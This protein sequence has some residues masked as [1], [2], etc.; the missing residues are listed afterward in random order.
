MRLNDIL[1]AMR[2]VAE[3]RDLNHLFRLQIQ[4][5][6]CELRHADSRNKEPV[7]YGGATIG[8]LMLVKKGRGYE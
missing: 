5:L 3:G 1:E 8:P 4:H 7:D 2:A 6:S